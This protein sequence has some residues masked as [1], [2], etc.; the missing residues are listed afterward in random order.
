MEMQISYRAFLSYSHSDRSKAAWLHRTLE[1]YRVPS[2]LI[3]MPTA[4]GPVPARLSPVFRDREELSA[5]GN[6]GESIESA[7]ARSLAPV[8]KITQEI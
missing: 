4:F 7:L 5:A 8:R 2:K 1:S 3:G 6:L